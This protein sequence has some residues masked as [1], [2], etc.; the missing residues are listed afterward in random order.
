MAY[1]DE[2]GN[3]DFDALESDVPVALRMLD[4]VITLNR[5]PLPEIERMTKANRSVG[6][7]IMGLRGSDGTA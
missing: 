6:I 7:G 1:V 2:N 4:N 3:F 5:Y